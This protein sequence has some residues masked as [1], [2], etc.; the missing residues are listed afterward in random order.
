MNMIELNQKIEQ[1]VNKQDETFINDAKAIQTNLDMTDIKEWQKTLNELTQE[2]RVLRVG[3]IGRVK[4]G[5][6]SMLN[7]LL[8]NGE[9]ILPKA[10]TPM[11]AALTIMEYSETLRAE[12][13]FYTDEDIKEIEQK[14]AKHSELLEQKFQE[15]KQDLLERLKRKNSSPSSMEEKECSNKARSQAE[16]EMKNESTFAAYDQYERIK[17]SGKTPANLEQYKHIEANNLNDLMNGTLNKFV[18]ANG[19]FMP[20]TKSITLYLPEEGLKGLQI[21]DTPGINDPVTSRGARTEQLLQKCDVVLIVSPSGQF[22]SSE[23]TDLLYRVIGKEGI[24]HA[25]LIASQVDNQ[26][27]GSE[28]RGVSNPIDVLHKVEQTL[29]SH[30]RN[31]LAKPEN[32]Q[33]LKVIADALNKNSVICSSSVAYTMSQHL[34]AQH[35]WDNN[36]QHVWTQLNRQFPSTFG[37]P[38]SAKAALDQLANIQKLHGIVQKVTQEKEQILAQRRDDFEKQKYK[39]LQDYIKALLA[40]IDETLD[41]I[42]NSD[43]EQIKEQQGT[44]KNQ[45]AKFNM[46]IGNTYDALISRVKTNLDA[47]LKSKLNNEMNKFSPVVENAQDKETEERYIYKG[48]RFIFFGKKMYDTVYDSIDTVQT[49]PIKKAILNIRDELQDSL[50][51]LVFSFSQNFKKELYQ[52]IVGVIRETMGDD[53]TDDFILDRAL[54]N[55]LSKIPDHNFE[56]R[57]ALPSQLNKSSKLKGSEADSYIDAAND[58]M[59]NLKGNIRTQI[60]NYIRNLYSELQRIDLAKDFTQDLDQRINDLLKDIENKQESL[61][62]YEQMKKELSQLQ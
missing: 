27:F 12:V 18:G 9:N 31:V 48:R 57:D 20:F 16:R 43:V 53:N 44:L 34:D 55:V 23:D 35:Q 6:S 13:E 39:L 61:Y 7:A 62:R 15:K 49:A 46:S 21:I 38:S 4:A 25:Y 36:T 28:S 11:T 8:F 45:K 59:H 1:F 58:Y 54:K 5:K 33:D 51:S 56:L 47:E 10:A 30:A 19:E 40:N 26:L 32:Q 52:K 50:N 37:S 2:G 22:L 24:A 42:K 17:D 3:I 14:H 41:K 60:D 29:T